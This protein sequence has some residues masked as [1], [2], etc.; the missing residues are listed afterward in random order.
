MGKGVMKETVIDA[1]DSNKSKDG[2]REMEETMS[3]KSI[4]KFCH[5]KQAPNWE[6]NVLRLPHS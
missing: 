6:I 3:F 1:V 2:V 4:K 5:C